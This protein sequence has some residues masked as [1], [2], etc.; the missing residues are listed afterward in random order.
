[1]HKRNAAGPRCPCPKRSGHKAI[2]CS[3]CSHAAQTRACDAPGH[4]PRNAACPRH[5]LARAQSR[6]LCTLGAQ[7]RA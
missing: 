5:H 3:L 2:P 1:L 6:C 4:F 7:T